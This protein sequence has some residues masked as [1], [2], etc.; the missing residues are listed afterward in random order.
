V[1]GLVFGGLYSIFFCLM[2]GLALV[3]DAKGAYLFGGLAV[4]PAAI[5][6]YMTQWHTAVDSWFNTHSFAFAFSFL[7]S[8]LFGLAL[9]GLL[10]LRVRI[11][12][13][14]LRRMLDRLDR[15]PL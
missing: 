9:Y 12:A 11:Q 10:R 4:F 15:D 7:L 13:Q 8:Y 6:V 3:T 5:V 1:F 14:R 2:S